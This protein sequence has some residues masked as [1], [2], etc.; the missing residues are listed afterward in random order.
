MVNQKMM[1]VMWPAFMAA[2]ALELLVFAVVDPQDLHWSGQAV[3]L[4]R[5]GVYTLAF[6]LFWLI[7]S[8]AGAMTVMLSRPS[9][10][11]RS[12]A[13]GPDAGAPATRRP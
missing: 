8:G 4:S 2:C 1:G 5:Q 12:G 10:Q 3:M 9:G 6:F 13:E 11:V 7:V